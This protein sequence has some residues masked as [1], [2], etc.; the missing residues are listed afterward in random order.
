VVL[1]LSQT[2]WGFY[3]PPGAGQAALPLEL[4]LGARHV[5]R[6]F[7]ERRLVL[8]GR[9]WARGLATESDVAGTLRLGSRRV[10]LRYE[11]EFRGRGQG[12]YR[13]TAEVVIDWGRP[14]LSLSTLTGTLV[15]PEGGCF[16]VELRYD[17][18]RDLRRLLDWE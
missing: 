1:V 14:L 3:R 18:R 7:R 2:L 13:L 16:E 4:E 10:P 11:L 17:Y 15:A 5:E 6:L 8:A 12:T 9:V